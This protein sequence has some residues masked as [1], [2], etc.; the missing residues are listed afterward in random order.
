MIFVDANVLLEVILK[1]SRS[2]ACEKFLRDGGDKAISVLSL[3]IVMYFVERHKLSAEPVKK[4][5]ESFEWLS[6][7]DTDAHRAF[8]RYGSNDFEDVL[9]VS[10]AV[11]EGCSSFAT[12]DKGLAK[13][14]AQAIKVWL[15]R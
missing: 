7:V 8:A 6:V 9:Q 2:S 11:R 3:D 12:L 14:Y 10:C 15:I 1:R 4:F 13:K 5:L